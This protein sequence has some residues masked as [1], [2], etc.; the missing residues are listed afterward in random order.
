[1]LRA[2]LKKEELHKALLN[3][4]CIEKLAVLI[5]DATFDVSSDAIDSFI[6]H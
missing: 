2:F 4:S 6:V 1:M 3:I 5:T